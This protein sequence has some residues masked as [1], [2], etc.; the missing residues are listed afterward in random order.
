VHFGAPKS[1]MLFSISDFDDNVSSQR[2][3]ALQRICTGQT[4]FVTRPVESRL[5][6]I[7]QIKLIGVR[8]LKMKQSDEMTVML[9]C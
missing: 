1:K 4:G 6:W 3:H 7:H 8:N 9:S 2:C 5:K